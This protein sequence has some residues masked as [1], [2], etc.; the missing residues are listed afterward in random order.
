MIR[1]RALRIVLVGGLLLL[2]G[3]IRS[4]SSPSSD[5]WSW[6]VAAPHE[7]VAGF[8]APPTPYA[9][10]HR[11]VDLAAAAGT[12]VRAVADGVVSYVGVVA[13]R[14]VLS[15]VHADDVLSS[16]EPVTAMVALGDRVSR[17]QLVGVVATGAHCSARC[18]HL[19]A[20]RHGHYLSPLLFLG[21]VPRAVLLP[22]P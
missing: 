15:I 17:G 11:G 2:P 10:G 9:A 20:R 1:R 22:L 14:P 13:D 21:G 6:P 3:G 5:A 16:V 12:P 4:S 19:G 7:V 8:A 18:L